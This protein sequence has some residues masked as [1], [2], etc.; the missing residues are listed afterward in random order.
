[1]VGRAGAAVCGRLPGRRVAARG[2]AP[3][4]PRAP[5]PPAAAG[6]PGGE[7]P[8][9][10]QA[11]GAEAGRRHDAEGAA[12]HGADAVWA[13]VSHGD[14]IKSVLADALGVHLDL[15]QRIVV[16]PASISVV[17]SRAPRRE[18]GRVHPRARDLSCRRRARPAGAAPVGGGAG[19]GQ[20]D[21]AR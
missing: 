1:M 19:P 10:T 9:A 7:P 20:A 16:G 18:D 17:R 3:R 15:F 21:A 5:P 6:C 14:V 12:R 13:A 11:R 4:G 2:A 8:A